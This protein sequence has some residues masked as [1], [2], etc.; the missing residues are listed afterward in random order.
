M[1][2]LRYFL[3]L[4]MLLNLVVY[5]QIAWHIQGAYPNNDIWGS[6]EL[7]GAVQS[8]EFFVNKSYVQRV[9]WQFT[10]SG[11]VDVMKTILA[12]AGTTR[13]IHTSY[14]YNEHGK[15][16]LQSA[17]SDV[18]NMSIRYNYR[19]NRLLGYWYNQEGEFPLRMVAVYDDAERL[20]EIRPSRFRFK[21]DGFAHIIAYDYQD[22][23]LVSI[24]N[25][26]WHEDTVL[27]D[28]IYY[29]DAAGRATGQD[30]MRESDIEQLRF[31]YEDD[32]VVAYSRTE[33]QDGDVVKEEFIQLIAEVL[34]AQGNW[35]ERQ[36]QNQQTKKIETFT[37]TIRY[38]AEE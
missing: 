33:L 14:S 19:D 1:K 4:G 18:D 25:T 20:I 36:W 32:A 22:D 26:F 34:D 6:L 21:Q 15:V 35:I 28:F 16:I 38:Y 27:Q 2:Q 7:H 8:V 37:R 24:Q 5:G 31:H 3:I 29:Y 13:T 11:Q 9:H 30:I 10:E 12:Y 23:Y 17:V